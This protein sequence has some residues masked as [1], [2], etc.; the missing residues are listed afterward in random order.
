MKWTKTTPLVMLVLWSTILGVP[1]PAVAGQRTKGTIWGRVTAAYIDDGFG[2]AS[3]Y[4]F[5]L[6]QSKRVRQVDEE[7]YRRAHARGIDPRQAAAIEADNLD[8]LAAMVP[9]LTHAAKTRTDSKGRYAV[10]GIPAGRRYYVVAMRVSEDGFFFAAGVTPM[11][12]AA[13]KL[14]FDLRDDEPW[15]KRF[16]LD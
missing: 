9:T 12:N 6:T 5:T 16:K 13:Q 7:A 11:L 2:D 15:E 4:V 8:A 14:R 1:H 10:T 3:V